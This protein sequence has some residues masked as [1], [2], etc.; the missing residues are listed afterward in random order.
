MN[1]VFAASGDDEIAELEG[2][3]RM[4]QLTADVAALDRLISDDLL[5]AGPDGRLATKA[6][7]LDAH[8]TGIVRFRKHEPQELRVRRVGK[9]VAIVSLETHL[10]VQVADGI[11][12][13][14]FRY[15]RVWARDKDGG[16]RVVGGQVSEIGRAQVP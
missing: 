7:D 3:L 13:G 15:T 9:N 1:D 4:A 16:W 5:F 11:S 6:Q 14:T 12:S 10:E 2:E 8:R